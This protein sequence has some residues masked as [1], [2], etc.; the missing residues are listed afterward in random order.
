MSSQKAYFVE[1]RAPDAS[2]MTYD[3]TFWQER[4]EA[5]QAAERTKREKEKSQEFRGRNRR[6]SVYADTFKII[7][8]ACLLF[9]GLMI[10]LTLV[11][12]D[13]F[14]LDSSVLIAMMVTALSTVFVAVYMVAKYLS[15]NNGQDRNR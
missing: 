5:I 6:L 8:V 3:Q 4:K 9:V 10:V 12:F 7:S 1:F 13:N 11:E 2:G 14:S 15:N